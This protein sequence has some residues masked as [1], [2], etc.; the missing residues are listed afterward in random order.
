MYRLRA[1]A[2][3]LQRLRQE[4]ESVLRQL[5][6]LTNNLQ[7]L[8]QQKTELLLQVYELSDRLRIV[9]QRLASNLNS[10]AP[11]N[12]GAVQDRADRLAP[13]IG[14]QPNNGIA[15]NSGRGY[16]PDQSVRRP[17]ISGGT[18]DLPRLPPG[19]PLTTESCASCHPGNVETKSIRSSSIS[20]F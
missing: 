14:T 4:H 8:A 18:P 7:E 11:G 10:E 17:G 16:A 13:T 12:T 2:G 1:Q 6:Q 5:A 3:E 15:A 20:I 9:S 19:H